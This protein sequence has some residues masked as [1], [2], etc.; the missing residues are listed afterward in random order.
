MPRF[1]WLLS[2]GFL[3][4]AGTAAWQPAEAVEGDSLAGRFVV[5][6]PE[7][8]DPNFSRT[9]VFMT[10]H[11]DAGAMGLVINRVI[12][13]GPLTRLLEGMG[14][15]AGP[16]GGS[17]VRVYAG[18]PVG[19]DLGFVLH[20]RDYRS[21]KTVA[22]DDQVALTPSL[23]VLKDIAAGK[24][25]R[26]SLVAFGYAGWAAG[27]LESEIAAGAWA[28]VPADEALLFDDDDASKWQ[29]AFARR[30]VDL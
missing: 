23:D 11:D 13:R 3:A 5:A 17:E 7:L 30:G 15:E 21:E 20:S 8:Q 4:L 9:V 6:T 18:G 27:Q 19:R 16:V 2:I 10:Q 29:R 25:P 14:V 24:G 26:E 28:I 1:V 12:A 22:V